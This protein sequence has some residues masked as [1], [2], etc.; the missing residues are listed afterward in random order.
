MV[1]EIASPKTDGQWKQELG[2]VCEALRKKG[3]EPTP[4]PKELTEPE[5]FLKIDVFSVHK[6]DPTG[7]SLEDL[8]P[9]RAFQPM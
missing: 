2:R 3:T 9:V 6:F 8:P 4:F 5:H 7:Y 1:R